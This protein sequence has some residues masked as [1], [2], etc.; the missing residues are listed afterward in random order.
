M[1]LGEVVLAVLYQP[2]LAEAGACLWSLSGVVPEV[3]EGQR[4]SVEFFE[5]VDQVLLSLTRVVFGHRP[6]GNE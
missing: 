2:G 1:Q 3:G 5:L 6:P 4:S